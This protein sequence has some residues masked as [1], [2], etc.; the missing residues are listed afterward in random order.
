MRS[1][2]TAFVLQDRDYLLRTWHPTTRPAELNL[3]GVQWLGLVVRRAQGDTV[4]FTAR[5]QEGKRKGEMREKSTF[6][7]QN[8]Q[9]FYLDGVE[10]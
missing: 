10:G 1:R 3:G 6:V 2:Y 4:S 9:W 8:G 7:K 5:Y